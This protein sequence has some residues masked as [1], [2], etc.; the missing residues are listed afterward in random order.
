MD[1]GKAARKKIVDFL[2]IPRPT[3]EDLIYNPIQCGYLLKFCKK[4][5][6]EENLEFVMA[7][8]KFRDNL[9]TRD[10]F[11]WSTDDTMEDLDQKTGILSDPEL[12]Y[13][14]DLA[15]FYEK[16]QKST[17]WP[18]GIVVR[19]WVER[20]VVRLWNKYLSNSSPTQI[21]IASHVLV[22]TIKRLKLFH[23]YGP[24]VFDEALIDP[25]KTLGRDILPRFLKSP[26]YMEMRD[27]LSSLIDL[28]DANS[29]NAHP[30]EVSKITPAR[31]A[32]LNVTMAMEDRV[33]FNDLLEYVKSLYAA[34]NVLAVRM[35][36]IFRA[37]WHTNTPAIGGHAHHPASESKSAVEKVGRER[38]D[39]SSSIDSSRSNTMRNFTAEAPDLRNIFR[40]M[41]SEEELHEIEDFAWDIFRYFI[42]QGSAYEICISVRQARDIMWQLA[43]PTS[44]MFDKAETSALIT[45]R[46]HFV[47]YK[48]SKW[49]P[50]LIDKV[51]QK[52][53]EEEAQRLKEMGCFGSR[54]AL[55]ELQESLHGSRHGGPLASQTSFAYHASMKPTK[56]HPSV[57]AH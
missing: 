7:V 51:Q 46:E 24:R 27:R 50:G 31:C 4:E 8:Q 23:V 10:K 20:D 13:N 56:A 6:N 16:N 35:I 40:C 2:A 44:D 45:V 26:I 42:T 9:T 22:N 21:C 25:Q 49:F 32:F 36:R 17:R 28:P 54:S 57:K 34:E 11:G 38:T 14:V 29:L 37:M 53:D 48:R 55:A 39:S 15:D 12:I 1:F 30:P 33:V 41:K 43:M 3:V 47:A 18:S 52:C 5:Y 19:D